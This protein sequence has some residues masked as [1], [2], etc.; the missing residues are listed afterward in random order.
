[1]P[2]TKHLAV[3]GSRHTLLLPQKVAAARLM[4]EA[5]REERFTHLHMGDCSGGDEFLTIMWARYKDPFKSVIVHPP[6]DPKLRIYWPSFLAIRDPKPYLERNLD[7]VTDSECLIAA[8]GQMSE[9]LRSGTWSTIRYARQ[10][11]I[12]IYI[13]QPTGHII[14][15]MPNGEVTRSE[16]PYY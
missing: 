6:E 2:G 7:M 4:E 15:E 3:T 5:V 8:P 11:K 12:P 13:I 16:H 14:T 10:K 1:M 9:S